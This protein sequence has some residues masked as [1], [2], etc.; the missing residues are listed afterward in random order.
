MTN[1]GIS[2]EDCK[3]TRDDWAFWNRQTRVMQVVTLCDM[4]FDL[5]G[6][7][8]HGRPAVLDV[9]ELVRQLG[10]TEQGPLR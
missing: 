3:T 7:P 2:M 5:S 9:G 8:D 4:S 1:D 6:I 10:R